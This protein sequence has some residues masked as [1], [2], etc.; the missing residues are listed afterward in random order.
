ML[1]PLSVPLEHGGLCHSQ[2]NNT[3]DPPTTWLPPS[4]RGDPRHGIRS[5]LEPRTHEESSQ[6]AAFLSGKK[7][8][9]QQRA[10]AKGPSAPTTLL[11]LPH[12]GIFHTTGPSGSPQPLMRKAPP[13]T[14]KQRQNRRRQSRPRR[15]RRRSRNNTPHATS[16]TNVA[17]LIN[18]TQ[19][20][21][22][23]PPENAVQP[24]RPCLPGS[25][26]SSQA[27]G[28]PPSHG[29]AHRRFPQPPKMKA[30]TTHY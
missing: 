11:L 9:R 28:C 24:K 14:R 4:C 7:Q 2:V 20:L 15:R 1:F 12:L 10:P 13:R 22:L 26:R 29:T 16:T 27:A 5:G 23:G 21:P 25:S 17:S 18:A 8:A 3:L 30:P 6:G 19:H